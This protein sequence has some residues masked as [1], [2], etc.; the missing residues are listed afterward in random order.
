VP[1]IRREWC[2]GVVALLGRGRHPLSRQWRGNK[3]TGKAHLTGVVARCS[4]DTA[5]RKKFR[6]VKG[7]TAGVKRRGDAAITAVSSKRQSLKN[8]HLTAWLWPS[9]WSSRYALFGHLL[10][11]AQ[12]RN[13]LGYQNA[14]VGC[15][16][17][18]R[19]SNPTRV[20]IG[21]T[22]PP[23]RSVCPTITT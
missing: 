15:W 6:S 7:W 9:E 4:D 21:V 16:L 2:C 19:I 10:P 18:H 8:S 22:I 23:C 13:P 11:T 20:C 14:V 12:R 1:V 5:N 3:A 17:R